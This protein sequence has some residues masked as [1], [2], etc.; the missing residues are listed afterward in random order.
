VTSA[1]FVDIAGELVHSCRVTRH[2]HDSESGDSHGDGHNHSGSLQGGPA[3]IGAA[4]AN[5][6]LLVVQVI[7]A[8]AFGSLALLADSVHQASDVVSLLMAVGIALIVARP[9][10]RRFTFGLGRADA[11]GGLAHALIL[12][13]GAVFIVVEAIARFGNEVEV[14]G[15]GV[16]VLALVGVVVNAASAKWLHGV[17]GHSLNMQGAVLHLVADTLGSVVVLVSGVLIL[18]TGVEWVDPVASI[19]VTLLIVASA[20]RLLW[21]ALRVLLDGVPPSVDLAGLRDVLLDDPLVTDAH[22]VHVRSLDGDTLSLTAH[23]MIDT[24]D[25]HDAQMVTKRLTEVLSVEG[26]GHVTLQAECH[27]CDEPGC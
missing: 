12:M 2:G 4:A 8:V 27:P 19:L 18:T 10:S 3:L 13:A 20:A 5:T 17:G 24:S 7:G 23:V 1:S 15:G 16:V 11:L 6:L 9:S 25:L 26:I 22:H 21:A 14:D